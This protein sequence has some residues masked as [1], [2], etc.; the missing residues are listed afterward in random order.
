MGRVLVVMPVYNDLNACR[1]VMAALAAVAA[2]EDQEYELL[3]VDDGSNNPTSNSAFLRN[4]T[5]TPDTVWMR[6]HTRWA[7]RRSPTMEVN[8]INWILLNSVRR[9]T[10]RGFPVTAATRAEEKWGTM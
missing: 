3:I 10:T 1:Q 4:A 9:F 8:S 7:R 2:A 5:T 6:P